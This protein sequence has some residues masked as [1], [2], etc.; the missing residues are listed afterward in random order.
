M[1]TY[2]LDKAA[3]VV[4]DAFTPASL[5]ESFTL[6]QR[7]DRPVRSLLGTKQTLEDLQANLPVDCLP[8]GGTSIWGATLLESDEI[9][10]GQV[11]VVGHLN[12]KERPERLWHT[13]PDGT[14]VPVW[15]AVLEKAK[16]VPEITTIWVRAEDGTWVEEQHVRHPD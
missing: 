3:R 2:E 6:V 4:V 10:E 16:V 14:R 15:Y 7:F 11:L 8:A 5:S 13:F 9:P 12:Q 1:S